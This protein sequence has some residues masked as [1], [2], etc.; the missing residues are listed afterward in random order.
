MC[1]VVCLRGLFFVHFTVYKMLIWLNCTVL[2]DGME[3][4]VSE[5]LYE[6]GL[7]VPRP[8]LEDGILRPNTSRTDEFTR[9]YPGA[10]GFELLF[11][12]DHFLLIFFH[13]VIS[14]WKKYVS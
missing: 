10:A 12:L 9:F 5:Y 2:R 4:F 14:W 11:L 1:R 13:D 6:M 7:S 8:H 3:Y